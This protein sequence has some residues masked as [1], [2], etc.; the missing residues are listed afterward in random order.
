MASENVSRGP[1][2]YLGI[3]RRRWPYVATIAPVVVLLSVYLAF[4]IPAEYRASATIMLEPSSVQRELIET[5]VASYAD[6]QIEIVQG[7]VMTVAALTELVKAY[8]PYPDLVGWDTAAKAHRIIQDTSFERVDPVTMK[9]LIESTAFSVHYNNAD[10]ERAAAVARRLADLFLTYNQR[11]RV[12][13]AKQTAVFL[14]EQAAAITKE[15][16][17]VDGELARLKQKYGDALPDAQGRN[18]DSLDRAQRDLDVI[19]R[20]IRLEEEKESMLTLQLSQISPNLVALGGDLTDFAKVKAQLAEAEQRYTPDHPDVKRLRRAMEDLIAK[21]AA[22]V[23]KPVKPN[24]P[25]YLR[26]DSQLEG[27][28]RELSA[29][30]A[31]AASTRAKISEYTANLRSTPTV[32]REFSDVARRREGLQLKSQQLQDRLH[33]AQL[34]QSFE[35]ESRGERFSMVRAPFAPEMPF[36]PNRIGMILL[37][38]VLGFG[39]TAVVVSIVE[40]T[41]P[42]IRDSGDLPVFSGASLLGTIPVI[43]TAGDRRRRMLLWGSVAGAYCI[44]VAFVGFTVASA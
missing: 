39:L 36:Y 22:G 18:E 24:N 23:G 3:I 1:G 41:D 34:A 32:E 29:L 44:A 42:T 27:V 43:M 20:E 16:Q 25:D 15:L 31:S 5:T 21:N 12:E 28:R 13:T 35:A 8:D 6:R 37:G 33:N 26:I 11:T 17:E 7:K 10:P 19:Q 38:L 2:D 40:S 30:R 9:T 14:A 4:S